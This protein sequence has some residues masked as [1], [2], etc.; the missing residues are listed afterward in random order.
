MG[1]LPNG[2]TSWLVNGGDPNHLTKW[3]DHPSNSW[4]GWHWGVFEGKK[5]RNFGQLFSAF[6]TNLGVGQPTL[7]LRLVNFKHPR[8]RFHLFVVSQKHRKKKTCPKDHL[9]LQWKDFFSCIVGIGSSKNSRPLRGQ[10]P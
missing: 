8:M 7:E 6:P 4:L 10:D 3:D 5:K 1:P 2:R 9:T